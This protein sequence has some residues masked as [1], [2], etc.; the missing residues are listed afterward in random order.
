MQEDKDKES[1]PSAEGK[2]YI[3]IKY[4]FR[5]TGTQYMFTVSVQNYS[6]IESGKMKSEKTKSETCNIRKSDEQRERKLVGIS[7]QSLPM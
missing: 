2:Q 4:Y 1:L 3:C 6:T 5:W 7:K